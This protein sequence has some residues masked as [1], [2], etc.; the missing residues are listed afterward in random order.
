MISQDMQRRAPRRAL[1]TKLYLLKIGTDTSYKLKINYYPYY[2]I[3]QA[4]PH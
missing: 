1:Q 2:I 4:L 3:D